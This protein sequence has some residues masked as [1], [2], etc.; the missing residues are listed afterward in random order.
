MSSEYFPIALCLLSAV[1]VAATNMFVKRSG[2]VLSTRMIVSIAMALSVLPFAPFVPMPTPELWRALAISVV[3]HW[4]YQ[5][6]MIRALHR[7]DL[8]L[9]FPVMRGLAPLL[10]ALMAT[11]FL[12]ETTSAI[13]WFGL[14]LATL[15]LIVF[16]LPEQLQESHSV[17]LRRAALFWAAVTAL[18]IAAYSVVDARGSRIAADAGSVMTFVVWLFLLDWIGISTALIVSRRNRL[19]ASIRPHIQD[20]FIGGVLGTISYG[21]ALWAFTM[22]QAANVTAIR[23][24]SVVFGAVFGAVFLKE[25]F[26]HRR[27][28]AACILAFGLMLL[29]FAP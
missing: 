26:G 29:E 27:V 3:V 8:S 22:S 12:A 6:A 18:G 28:V 25:S 16:A 21:A 23:E 14:C 9:V 24:T 11:L 13:G 4:G 1:T 10:T 7:G 2:D 5:F 20:G 15:A 19:W 17:N